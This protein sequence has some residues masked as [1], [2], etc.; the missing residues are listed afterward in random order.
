MSTGACLRYSTDE[1]RPTSIDDQFRNCESIAKREGLS[2][3]SKLKF[4]DE[5]ITGKAE[6]TSKRAGYRRLLDAIEAREC[7]VLIADELSRITRHYSEGARL[8]DIVDKTGLRIITGDG[9]DT[10]REGW[11]LLWMF[12]LMTAAQEV[13][14]SSSR[15]SRGMLGALHRGFQIAP[16][17]FGYR[18]VREPAAGGKTCMRWV[19]HNEEAEIVRTIFRLRREGLSLVSISTYLKENNVLPPRYKSAK[20]VPYWRPGAIFRLLSNSIYRGIFIWNG[21][22]SFRAHARKRRAQVVQQEFERESCRIVSDDDW[23]DCNKREASRDGQEPRAPRAG[24]QHLFTGMVRC[25]DCHGLLCIGGGPKSFTLYCPQCE[26][27]TRIGARSSW[28]GYSSV[29]AARQAIEFGLTRLF[30]GE[31]LEEFHRRLE[32]R[33][34]CG[35]AQEEK[36]LREKENNIQASVSRLKSLIANPALDLELFQDDLVK[37]N[38]Q[39]RIVRKRLSTLQEQVSLLTPAV[40]EAQTMIEPLVMLRAILDG[41]LEVYKVRATLRRLISKFELVGRPRSGC[42]L[43]RIEFVPGVCVA[44][45]SGTPVMDS[46]TVTFEIEVT[47]PKRRPVQWLVSGK[48]V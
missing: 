5:A 30:T 32:D 44:E 11:K 46:S 34:L 45:L 38:D 39:L 43:Y 33:L 25:G 18:A 17:P 3:D 40:L 15:T 6:G 35:P 12:K 37:A 20:G 28:I 26:S 24:G 14:N 48:R 16:P 27:A 29:G 13:E 31:V 4:S 19:I 22:V 21:S 41:Q 7:T 10:G 1:Q 2:I 47:A 36:E 9:I 42:S 8:M 23:Y